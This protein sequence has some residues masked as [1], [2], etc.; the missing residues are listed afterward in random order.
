[1][2]RRAFLDRLIALLGSTGLLAVPASTLLYA[3]D[4]TPA[5]PADRPYQAYTSAFS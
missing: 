2:T 4:E 1:M 5:P 3:Q